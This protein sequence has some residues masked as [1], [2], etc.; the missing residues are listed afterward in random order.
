MEGEKQMFSAIWLDSKDDKTIATVRPVQEQL[1]PDGDVTLHVR[2]S[3]LN[4]KD[5]LAITG[6]MPVVRR[7]PLIPGI[8]M[9]GTVIESTHPDWQAGDSAL[10]CGW[11]YGEVHFGGLAEKARVWG[12]NLTRI[13]AGMDTRSVM[14]LGTA[15][16][17]AA[18]AVRALA[19]HGIQPS[20]GKI[21]VTGAGGGVG[22]LAIALLKQRDYTV[23]A[24]S[25]RPSEAQ[26]LKG[27]GAAEVIDRE[28]LSKPGKILS[29]ELWAGAVDS[30]GSHTLA[31]VCAATRAG[32]MVAACGNA[33]GMDF[34][35]SVAPFIL[36]GVTLAGVNSVYVPPAEREA[37]WA[38][39]AALPKDVIESIAREVTLDQ[40]IEA[41]D[42]IIAG[43]V[44]GRIVVRMRTS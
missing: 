32:G 34:V 38:D 42:S 21:L 39:L 2:Y 31:N 15:G 1:L 16:F 12:R 17:T 26:R 8:D 20:S 10:Q 25:G 9:A 28:T 43:Q 6:K 11:E 23:V 44:S 24:S 7:F 3:C 5:A 36:R 33:Q 29:K 4:Y 22:G 37:A 35:G 13:P 27:L 18:L 14:A 40:A 19:K 41:A 30:L